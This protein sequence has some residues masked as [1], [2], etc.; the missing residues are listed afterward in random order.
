[1]PHG[2]TS[3]G[4][5]VYGILKRGMFSRLSRMYVEKKA[6]VGRWMDWCPHQRSS[7]SAAGKRAWAP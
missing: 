3:F 7:S 2:V 4:V 6:G 1:M 5:C